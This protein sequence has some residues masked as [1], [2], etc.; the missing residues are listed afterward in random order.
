MTT[1]AIYARQS[2]DVSEGIERQ[3]ARCRALI[4]ARGYDLVR[5]YRDN[6]TSAA[7]ERGVGTAWATML[8][9]LANGVAEVVVAV[10]LDRLL[11]DTRDLFR[12][13]DAGARVL[14]VDGELDLTTADGEFR[15][16][17][18]AGIA[19][20]EIR[21]KSERQ[22]RANLDRASRGE[23]TA[24]RRRFGYETDAVTPRETEAIVVR[25]MFQHVADGGSLRSL[26]QQLNDE[27]VDPAPGRAAWRPLR[28]RHILTNPHY[29]GSVTHLGR[30][31]PSDTVTPIVT[32]E[33]AAEVQAILADAARRTSPGPGRRYLMSGLARCGVCGAGMH[34]MRD[35]RCSASTSHP[36]ITRDRLE[37]RVREE[38]ARA[39]LGGGSSLFPARSETSTFAAL[40][41]EHRRNSDA[42]AALLADRD[43]GLVPPAAA[44]SRLLALR[45]EREGLERQLDEARVSKSAAS[46]LVDAAQ[47]LLAEL[48]AEGAPYDDV[49]A[50]LLA[51]FD[52]LDLDRQREI[53][54]ALLYVEVAP[55][56]D[57]RRVRVEHL[58]APGLN[59]WEHVDADD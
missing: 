23:P 30:V 25:R 17:M 52:E 53:V 10:D 46:A 55:G 42:V 18:L 39:L 11:R 27:G 24:G 29:A 16:T 47:T 20:F 28:L 1:V 9:E 13:I 56:R 41:A 50:A 59:P 31:T 3:L 15:A 36:S 58:L 45:E 4:Q 43:E 38:I 8:E 21:R 37:G 12:L 32:P 34:F 57:P 26:A 40:M 7:K 49:A 44:R 22:L 19:R 6:D 48:P 14:T 35:Y 54:S 51:R 33:L 2:E 5:E